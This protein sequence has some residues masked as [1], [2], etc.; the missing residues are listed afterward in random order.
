MRT[1]G[2]MGIAVGYA[3]SLCKKYDTDP[4]GVYTDHIAELKNLI[5]NTN[6]SDP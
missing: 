1:C 5:A 4:R 3:G 2:Q 6:P